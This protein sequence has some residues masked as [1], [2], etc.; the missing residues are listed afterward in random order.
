MAHQI[1]ED[2]V[3]Y[4]ILARVHSGMDVVDSAGK[5]LGTV[6]YVHFG[7]EDFAELDADAGARPSEGWEN[8]FFGALVDAL[9]GRDNI[10]HE[11][12]V[13]LL[14]EGY[15]HIDGGLFVNDRF[16]VPDQIATVTDEQVRLNVRGDELVSM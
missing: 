11:T 5:R 9:F 12:E 6:T 4:G 8:S 15:I 13:R 16:A 7:G 10:P 3:H 2:V 14:R 1:G